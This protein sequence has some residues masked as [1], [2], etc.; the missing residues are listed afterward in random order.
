MTDAVERDRSSIH[1][2]FGSH[3]HVVAEIVRRTPPSSPIAWLEGS[4]AEASAW[5]GTRQLTARAAELLEPCMFEHLVARHRPILA[6]LYPEATIALTKQERAGRDVLRADSRSLYT[7]SAV[8]WQPL[9]QAAAALIADTL[10]EMHAVAAVPE[11]ASLDVQTRHALVEAFR[12]HGER[13]ADLYIGHDPALARDPLVV[14][15]VPVTWDV[16]RIQLQLRDYQLGPRSEV[17]W[18]QGDDDATVPPGPTNAWS[19]RSPDATALLALAA[20][21]PPPSRTA[22]DECVFALRWAASVYAFPAAFRIGVLLEPYRHLLD[23]AAQAEHAALTAIAAT[24]THFKD[25]PTPGFDDL[26]YAMYERAIELAPDAVA[27]AALSVRLAFAGVDREAPAVDAY[28]ERARSSVQSTTDD[29]WATYHG[30]WLA[31]AQALHELHQRKLAAA[32]GFAQTACVQFAS[33]VDQATAA[34]PA[35]AVDGLRREASCGRFLVLS[36]G[37]IRAGGVDDELASR[38]LAQAEQ[39]RSQVPVVALFEVFH[40]VL[41]RHRDDDRTLIYERCLVGIQDAERCW[42]SRS[43]YFY[44]S[45]AADCAYRIGRRHEAAEHCRKLLRLSANTP[46]NSLTSWA[47]DIRPLALRV[48]LR[49]GDHASF[50]ELAQRWLTDPPG[51]GP[52]EVRAQLAYAHAMRGEPASAR[53]AIELAID[54]AIAGG[55]HV[56]MLR[57]ATLTVQV[58]VLLDDRAESL[59]ALDS[60]WDLAEDE[61]GRFAEAV[62]PPDRL[63][64]CVVQSRIVGAT[65][66]L[67]SRACALLPSCM[68]EAESWWDVT[69]L[70]EQLV[71]WHQ[72]GGALLPDMRAGLSSV[73]CLASNR[74]DW[75]A[76]LDRLTLDLETETRMEPDQRPRSAPRTH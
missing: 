7:H 42:E 17:L 49:A 1:V 57:V 69:E 67:L 71:G 14:W 23:P 50:L 66:A 8:S 12:T 35:L 28:I 62:P 74:A 44:R 73:Q 59:R 64:L 5:E 37:A 41:L 10:E 46:G 25:V 21:T 27:M 61:P 26:L 55:D 58:M 36:H 18:L 51:P 24:N 19:H 48:F 75:R 43:W 54:E 9:I 68:V 15:G 11:L 20:L 22:L 3:G 65:S 72:R 4:P 45:I 38:W 34:W 52:A 40:W 32:D 70:L 29:L 76:F 53:A 13:L 30:A 31:V 56:T 60:A 16:A 63:R 6:L 39:E 2:L 47:G 33:A